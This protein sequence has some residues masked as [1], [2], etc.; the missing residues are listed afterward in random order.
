LP[1]VPTGIHRR[2]LVGVTQHS[3][4]PRE[5]F[6]TRRIVGH[7]GGDTCDDAVGHSG[8]VHGQFAMSTKRL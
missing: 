5:A 8:R 3:R 2:R 4:Y 1:T 6:L 7:R